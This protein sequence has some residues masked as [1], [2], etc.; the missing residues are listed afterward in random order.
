MDDLIQEFIAETRETL[1]A[2]SGE[3]VAWEAHPED[4]ARLDAGN[5]SRGSG[6]R[7]LGG[8]LSP[9]TEAPHRNDRESQ[10]ARER[11]AFPILF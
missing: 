2:L 7:H 11:G 1:E 6:L 9:A 8:C 3:V 10:R 4:R 5:A